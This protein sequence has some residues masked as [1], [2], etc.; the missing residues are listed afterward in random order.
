MKQEN[1]VQTPSEE[2]AK[3]TQWVF[4]PLPKALILKRTDKYI[5]FKVGDGSAVV[6]TKF[7]RAKEHEDTIFL[8]VPEN[9]NFGVKYNSYDAEQKKFV[10]TK[11]IECPANAMRDYLSLSEEEQSVP[12]DKWL[13]DDLPF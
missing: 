1:Q 12:L 2:V 13:E 6:S 4:I 8:S 5:L 11:E 10:T 3:T 7:K 9:Y